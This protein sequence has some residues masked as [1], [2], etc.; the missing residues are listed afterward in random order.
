MAP[1]YRT[2]PSGALSAWGSHTARG[3]PSFQS[4]TNT[5]RR[6]AMSATGPSRVHSSVVGAAFGRPK[7][8]TRARG[9]VGPGRRGRRTRDRCRE[10]PRRSPHTPLAEADEA[11]GL[12][13]DEMVEDLDPEELAGRHQPACQG[14]VL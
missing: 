2:S 7:S 12:V 5:S 13:E 10:S 9:L 4:S 14:H 1:P 6:V 8:P 3:C 11:P